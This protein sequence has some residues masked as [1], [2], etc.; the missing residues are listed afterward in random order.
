MV[1]AWGKCLEGDLEVQRRGGEGGYGEYTDNQLPSWVSGSILL[2]L[3]SPATIQNKP[4]S[5]PME[6]QLGRYMPPP[7]S[8]KHH[9][10]SSPALFPAWVMLE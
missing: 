8:N 10:P 1:G 9:L 5:H 7:Y 4:Q 6:G 2:H 3:T